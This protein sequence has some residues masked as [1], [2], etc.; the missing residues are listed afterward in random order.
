MGSLR[1]LSET[2]VSS[3]ACWVQ[4]IGD[5][6]G[7]VGLSPSADS[8]RGSR[9]RR[10]TAAHGGVLR[11]A[12]RILAVA[13]PLGLA[14]AE[15]VGQFRG[16]GK[17]PSRL[18]GHTEHRRRGR[19]SVLG[20]VLQRRKTACT[21]DVGS[22]HGLGLLPVTEATEGSHPWPALH[23][24]SC[25]GS[26]RSPKSQQ[27]SA[28][29]E[30]V[31]HSAAKTPTLRRVGQGRRRRTIAIASADPGATTAT[32][33]PTRNARNGHACPADGLNRTVQNHDRTSSPQHDQLQ[34]TGMKYAKPWRLRALWRTGEPGARFRHLARAG[35]Q[36]RGP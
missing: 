36:A 23:L 4:A 34:P 1:G 16:P 21:D 25:T 17:P 26:A 30:P 10:L 24:L 31:A 35:R 6:L 8:D 18:P 13:V 20:G 19:R 2:L 28:T 32:P 27:T 29:T 15:S 22:G 5:S 12:L 11:A 9:R 33:K 3:R 7:S 14:G